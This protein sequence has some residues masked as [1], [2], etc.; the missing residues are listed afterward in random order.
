MNKI[1]IA[2][3]ETKRIVS[4]ARNMTVIVLFIL[5][6]TVAPV[7]MFDEIINELSKILSVELEYIINSLFKF[8][9]FSFLLSCS[10]FVIFTISMDTF[11]SDKKERALDSVLAAPVSLNDVWLGKSAALFIISYLTSIISTLG[12]S[13]TLYILYGHW[14]KDILSWVY[15][16]T[17]FPVLTFSLIS[18]AG[19]AQLISK[20]FV[21][22]STGIFYISFIFMFLSSFLV[23]QLLTIKPL[24]L[25]GIYTSVAI[26]LIFFNWIARKKIF[27]KEK[28]I[29]S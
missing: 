14:P 26:L 6:F 11:V 18:L 3:E 8:F 27:T 29:L 23:N 13:L 9:V 2:T 15:L 1:S 10:L 4:Y 24:Y 5:F 17:I 16:F 22:I 28:I 25:F 19:I 21:G 7:F 20:R 12:F